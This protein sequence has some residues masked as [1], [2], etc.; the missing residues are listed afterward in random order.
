MSNFTPRAWKSQ[1]G[2]ETEHREETP[3]EQLPSR[4]VVTNNLPIARTAFIGRER[5]VSHVKERLS[6]HRLLTLVG[7]GGVGKTRLALQVGTELIDLYPDGVW[8][9]D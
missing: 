5:D 3:V 2:P 8:F 6:R 9:V 1:S 4:D 7:S